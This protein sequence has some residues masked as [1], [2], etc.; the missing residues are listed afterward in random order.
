MFKIVEDA[1]KKFHDAESVFVDPRVFLPVGVNKELSADAE[2]PSDYTFM[3]KI[4]KSIESGKMKNVITHANFQS[5]LINTYKE[6]YWFVAS[7]VADWSEKFYDNENVIHLVQ[8]PTKE[9]LEEF[10]AYFQNQIEKG[11]ALETIVGAV[12]H[13]TSALLTDMRK[14]LRAE[15]RVKE[16]F[17]KYN[18]QGNSFKVFNPEIYCIVKRL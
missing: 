9:M 17:L 15:E 1:A 5:N 11:G 14:I 12:Y 10:E 13:G 6:R 3:E 7:K 4:V 8:R 16:A 2:L 18:P